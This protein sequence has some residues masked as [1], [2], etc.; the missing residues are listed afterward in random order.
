VH[1]LLGHPW[2]SCCAGVLARLEA[3]GLA[4]RIVA[5]PLIPPARLDWRFDGAGLISRLAFEGRDA[6][7]ASVLIR[8]AGWLDAEG[9]EP[10]D[11]AYMQAET[12]AATLAWLAGLDCPVVNRADAERW[13]RPRPPLLAW[14]PLLRRCGLATADVIV[15]NDPEDARAFGMRHAGAVYAPLT[16]S[17]GYLVADDEGWRGLAALQE[18]TLACLVEPHGPARP[19]CVV[20]NQVIW[21][22]DPP[23][24]AVALAP[25]LLRFAAEAGLQFVALAVAPVHRG[26]GV[27]LVDPLPQLESFEPPT[28][29]R[30][31]DAVAAL[32]APATAHRRTVRERRQ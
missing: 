20:G 14:R 3:R 5:A 27:V 28:R 1:L 24:E 11:H 16:G 30:I 2:D 19:A 4:A 13:Y 23:P 31:L 29:E 6:E 9:W 32:L 25:A 17:A 10:A 21:D 8:D 18:R 22:D 15:T 12:Q 26:L 7:I